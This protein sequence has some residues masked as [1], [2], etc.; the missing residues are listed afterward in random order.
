MSDQP[1]W[2]RQVH[3]LGAG[4]PPLPRKRLSLQTLAQGLE[5]T[6]GEPAYQRRA[7]DLGAQIRAERGVDRAVE[8]FHEI[9]DRRTT[10]SVQGPQPLK[11]P[12]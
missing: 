7:T 6:V 5:A 10:V 8:V 12:G 2:A 4:P 9:F 3:R 11:I 1:F